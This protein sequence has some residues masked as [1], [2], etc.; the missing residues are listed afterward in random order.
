MNGW[1]VTGHGPAWRRV[2]A[3]AQET[4]N[5]YLKGFAEPFL[6]AHRREPDISLEAKARV[7]LLEGIYKKVSKEN[8]TVEREKKVQRNRKKAAER[9]NT[10]ENDQKKTNDDETL[11]CVCAMFEEW[12]KVA[13]TISEGQSAA[14]GRLAG[15]MANEEAKTGDSL[16][17]DG[18]NDYGWKEEDLG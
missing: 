4:A 3:A 11:A 14:G 17:G 6:L 16:F 5:L 12:E 18:K 8:S 2:R 7:K 13:G 10:P 1:G 15:R 9:T